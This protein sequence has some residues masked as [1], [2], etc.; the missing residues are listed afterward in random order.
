MKRQIEGLGV[1]FELVLEAG[2]P[3]GELGEVRSGWA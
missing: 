1:L 3:F 2:Y